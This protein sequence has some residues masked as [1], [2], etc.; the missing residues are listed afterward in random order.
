MGNCTR[1]STTVQKHNTRAWLVSLLHVQGASCGFWRG[2]RSVFVSFV[3]ARPRS[4]GPLWRTLEALE[5]LVEF[6][7]QVSAP[8]TPV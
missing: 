8:A 7:G 3:G 4:I 6:P 5:W 2:S 1:N